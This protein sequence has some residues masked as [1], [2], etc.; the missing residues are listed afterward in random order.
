MTKT[1][2]EVLTSLGK[3]FNEAITTET[4]NSKQTETAP[5][6]IQNNLGFDIIIMLSNTPFKVRI[7]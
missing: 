7:K 5:Y 1:A 4:P 6:V 3:A 2:L